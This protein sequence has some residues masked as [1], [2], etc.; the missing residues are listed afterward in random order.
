MHKREVTHTTTTDNE[1]TNQ[2]TDHG[3]DTEIRPASPTGKCFSYQSIEAQCAQVAA[4]QLQPGI[5]R[6]GDIS[7]LQL[8]ISVD[9]SGQI[10]FSSSHIWWP[11]VGGRR[12][13]FTPPFNHNGRPFSIST[14][15]I[16]DQKLS[17]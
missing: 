9:T 11:F 10:G 15:L 12:V 1:Q 8:Q 3:Y 6:Q 5:G 4:K 17:H 14:T 7:K 16:S 2:K 13:G